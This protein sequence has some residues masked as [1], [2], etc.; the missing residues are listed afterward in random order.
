MKKF[1]TSSKPSEDIKN[2]TDPIPSAPEDDPLLRHEIGK[3]DIKYGSEE[4]KLSELRAKA[5]RDAAKMARSN[6]DSSEADE[7]DEINEDFSGTIPSAPEDDPLLR[8]EEGKVDIK[9]GSEEKELSELRAKAVRAAANMIPN[10]PGTDSPTPPS[11][12]SSNW[13][14][15]GPMAIP[16][17]QTYGGAR[18][19]VT[20][21]ITSIEVDPTTVNTMYVGTAQGGIWKTTDGGDNWIP[22]SDHTISLAIGALVMDPTNHLILYAGT[23]EGNFSGDSYYGNGILKTT[24]GGNTWTLHAETTF[25]G[26]RFCRLAI[27]PSNPTIIFAASSLGIYKSTNGGSTWSPQTN[28]LPSIPATDIAIDPTNP[29]NAYA[30]FWAGGIYKTTNASSS[31]PTW[32]QLTSGLPASGTTRIALS[33]SKS[34]SQT[35]YALISNASYTIDKFYVTTNGGTSWSS[36]PLP[37]GNIGGQGFYN[38]VVECDPTTPDIVYLA[39][40]ELWKAIRNPVSGA[41]AISK[42]GGTIHPDTHALTIDPTNHNILFCGNDGGIY[43]STNAGST[44]TDVINEGLCI[45]QFEF[46]EQHPTS[47]AVI[48]AGTQDNGTEQFRNSCV[49]YH[50]AD[51]DGGFCT[52]DYSNQN[53]YIHTYYSLSPERSI[54]AGK[55]GSYVYTGTGLSGSSLFY[56]P[57]A[58]DQS[59]SNNVAMGGGMLF[60]D[61][62]QGTNGWGTTITLGAGAGAISAIN[63]VNSN[64]LYLGTNTGKVY[65]VVKSGGTW[66]ATL[67]SASPFPSRFVWDLSP[68]PTD[69][70]TIIVVVSGF[71]T[72]HVWRGVISGTGPATWTDISGSGVTGLPNIPANALAIDS[73][74][75][76]MYVAT[77][78]GVFTSNDNGAT[79]INFSAGLPN[80]ATFDMRLHNPSRLLRVATHGRGMWEKKLDT[81]VMP[82]VDIFV[83]DNIMDTGRLIPSPQFIPAAF[84]DQLQHIGLGDLV[85]RWQCSDIKVDALEGSSPSYQM[86]VPDVDYVAFDSKL[87]HR[88]PQRGRMNRVYVQIHNRGIQP[89]NNVTV[90]ILYTNASAGLPPLPADFWTA[91]PNDSVDTTHW[92]PIGPAQVISSLPNTRPSILEWDWF[93]PV[94]AADHSC[95]LVVADSTAD[96]IPA[97]NKIFNVDNLGVIEKHV[98]FKN[99]AVV[100]AVPGAYYWTLFQFFGGEELGRIRFSPLTAK[101]W[102]IGI[103]FE[104]NSQISVKDGFV[105]K[106]PTN[107]M[108]IL[109]KKKI[110]KEIKEYDI[111]NIYMLDNVNK[112]GNLEL[113]ISKKG[114]RCMLLFIVPDLLTSGTISISQGNKKQTIGG[115]TFA[116]RSA[117]E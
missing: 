46:M 95:I 112:G 83:R 12:G 26:V 3:E 57:L 24:D 14:Q 65:R 7:K 64:L 16:N 19:L 13:V 43:K 109:L 47:D 27:N 33:I 42:I 114:V 105:R 4:K 98:G 55:F 1:S 78:I 88:N 90:K 115:T 117:K 6:S 87:E 62:A 99:L 58:V 96:P 69:S 30:A 59:N 103:I 35:V 77:D 9:Y 71:G 53:N 17:G 49:F 44:W 32:T 38:L 100:D 5:V 86:D 25:A 61:D 66:T 76:A 10:N 84:E 52:I 97:G 11:P 40:V 101:G 92:K 23:G 93:T 106:E 82:D 2:I 39:G 89:G 15:L 73:S 104:R 108:L 21:R 94:S 51:G 63:Y 45:T 34:S 74:T 80:V 116:L 75:N 28:G 22:T 31:N 68:L 20:G 8:H 50:S 111:S 37:G 56:P 113:K 70:N 110:K 60:L 72:G 36:I 48:L 81:S 41:W 54:Q 67:I 29:D 18:V 107:K 102:N 85:A 91:F 79:W